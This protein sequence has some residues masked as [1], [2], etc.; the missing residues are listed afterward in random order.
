C[1]L[2]D[3]TMRYGPGASRCIE[4]K[5]HRDKH[6][7]IGHRIIFDAERCILCTRCVRFCRDIVGTGE[8]GIGYRGDKAEIVLFPGKELDNPYSGN[9][10]DLCPVGALTSREYRFKA[11]PWD[12]VQQ[13]ET[14]CPAC[15]RG[16]SILLDVRH[17]REGGQEVLRVHP[18]YNPEVNGYWICDE[19]RFEAYPRRGRAAFDS[20]LLRRGDA[21]VAVA[22]EEA[23]STLVERLH[24][25]LDQHGPQAIG[26]L[27]STWLT[28]EELY[29]T[30]KFLQEVLQTP[31]LDYRVHPVQAQDRDKAEDHLLRRTDKSPNSQGARFLGLLPGPGGWGTREMLKAAARGG[32][33]ALFLFEVDPWEEPTLEEELRGV[34]E[35]LELLAVWTVRESPAASRAHLVFPA[36]GYTEKEGTI[37]NFAGRVQRLRRAVDSRGKVLTLREVLRQVAMGL[38]RPWDPGT[39]EE[40]W[41][42][43]A[44]DHPAFGGIQYAAIGSLGV[45][46]T[47]NR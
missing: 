12:L 33:K 13:V 34:R 22:W 39:P 43:L 19:G 37:I 41:H 17:L 26:G 21:Q 11:R 42:R 44:E 5:I 40:I 35:R 2:Q 23:I 30:G 45:P 6:R 14:T 31:H 20:P 8:L 29:T 18:R 32:L 9:V 47:D 28:T 15:S 38:H 7:P 25:I 4:E 1:P 27:L 16:C 46:V 24:G 3:Y 10:V 36:L